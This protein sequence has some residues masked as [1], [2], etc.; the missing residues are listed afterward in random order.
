MNILRTLLHFN[1]SYYMV[2]Y[3]I[4]VLPIYIKYSPV[5]SRTRQNPHSTSYWG[6]YE[7]TSLF[8]PSP[9]RCVLYL[10]SWPTWFWYVLVNREISERRWRW[11]YHAQLLFHFFYSWSSQIAL[12]SNFLF[13]F[14]KKSSFA[15]IFLF[16]KIHFYYIMNIALYEPHL[17][18]EGI[19]YLY[20]MY[21]RYCFAKR[22]WK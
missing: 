19:V 11:A 16:S 22:V 6:Q 4:L 9:I 13:L 12:E 3:D 17:T 2:G 10:G 18:Q 21:V 20:I 14:T 1:C 7:K 15:G 5:K 8:H